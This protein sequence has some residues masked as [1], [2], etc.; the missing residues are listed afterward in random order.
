MYTLVLKSTLFMLA[1]RFW[2][3]TMMENQSFPFEQVHCTNAYPSKPSITN[4]MNVSFTHKHTHTH[5]VRCINDRS[6]QTQRSR[7]CFIYLFIC[8]YI[9]FFVSQSIHATVDL[10][11]WSKR[12][13]AK[14]RW[15]WER[16]KLKIAQN[17]IESTLYCATNTIFIE[18]K[19]T[20]LEYSECKGWTNDMALSSI[21][22]KKSLKKIWVLVTF[23]LVNHPLH[24]RL[25]HFT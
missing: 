12:M 22:Y 25:L 18:N 8:C 10:L 11:L 19:R 15:E 23:L 4:R 21:P 24:T 9:L 2:L 3:C 17:H 20:N 1:Y 7:N 5:Y 6:I 14:K 13:K 16:E